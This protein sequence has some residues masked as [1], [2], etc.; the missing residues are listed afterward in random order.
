[1]EMGLL[2]SNLDK[3]CEKSLTGFAHPTL[4]IDS[5][6]K[7]F[8]AKIPLVEEIKTSHYKSW[9]AQAEKPTRYDLMHEY[10]APKKLESGLGHG[11]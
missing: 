9:H 10:K 2:V 6:R 1:M 5:L 8:K 7:H 11:Q 4:A 3:R